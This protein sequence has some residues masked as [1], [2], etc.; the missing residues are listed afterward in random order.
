MLP[1]ILSLLCCL[2]P[3][4][5]SEPE[6]VVITPPKAEPPVLVCKD[7]ES[8]WRYT[9]YE[10]QGWRVL[11]DVDL[12]ADQKLVADLLAILNERLTFLLEV[13]PT[14]RHALLQSIPIWVSNEPT[15][16]LR[17][18]E[19]GVIPFHRSPTWLRNHG[20][21]PQ[22]GPG[23]HIINPRPVL[24]EHRVFQHAP[25]TMLHE[26]AHAYHNLELG[27]DH[28]LIQDAYKNAM[29]LR[30]YDAV[31]SRSNPE[32]K[33]RAYAA[34]NHEEYFAELTEAWFGRNDWYPRNRDELK[35]HDPIGYEMIE[36]VW[37]LPLGPRLPSPP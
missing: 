17:P 4:A 7:G 35:Q 22:M 6:P 11:I 13:V 1:L 16:P 29:Q 12:S 33:A 25:E 34:T 27:L 19:R 9:A 23:V 18:G 37:N 36:T 14:Q 2:T 30:L 20:L 31:P 24:Y 8:I 32:V 15:Y 26:L 28:P 10:V 5:P 21:N 3:L